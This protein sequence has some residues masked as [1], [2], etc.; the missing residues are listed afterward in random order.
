MDA[1]IH[2]GDPCIAGTRVPVSLI[3]G[4]VADGDSF[5]QIL[6][7]YPQLKREDIQAALQFAAEA[8][9]RFDIVPTPRQTG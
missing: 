2:H 7:S 4:S 1:E 9:N 8:V 3:V 6:R 5:E